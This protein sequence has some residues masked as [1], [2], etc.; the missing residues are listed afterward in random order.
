MHAC[1]YDSFWCG[2]CCVCV[3]SV[4]VTASSDVLPLSCC[5][6]ARAGRVLISNA[7]SGC[8]VAS[9]TQTKAKAL[10]HDCYVAISQPHPHA[11]VTPCKPQGMDC[12]SVKK[13]GCTLLILLQIS[14]VA[15]LHCD[16]T[17]TMLMLHV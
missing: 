2:V 8:T 11:N 12:Y 16:K 10:S 3:G 6:T 5:R 17:T 1:G 15:T 14:G 9:V 13:P 4:R 7:R